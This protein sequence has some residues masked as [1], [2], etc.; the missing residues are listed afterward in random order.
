M[1]QTQSFVSDFKG[2]IL[3]HA[4]FP[5]THVN[6]NQGQTEP[7]NHRFYGERAPQGHQAGGATTPAWDFRHAALG[8]EGQG[9]MEV[10]GNRAP[11]G[12]VLCLLQELEA[13]GCSRS[14]YLR[15]STF[16]DT[17]I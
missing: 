17:S 4:E 2:W 10:C 14:I 13:F 5:Q 6:M 15:T 11:L 12:L 16:R 8:T 1:Q 7:L 3:Q 9:G